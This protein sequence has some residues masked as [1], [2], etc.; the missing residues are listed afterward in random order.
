MSAEN[1]RHVQ[2]LSWKEFDLYQ[3]AAL[4]W[5]L[6]L[7]SPVWTRLTVFHIHIFDAINS[8]QPAAPP[9]TK[10]VQAKAFPTSLQHSWRAVEVTGLPT[11]SSDFPILSSIP[12]V[13]GQ[14]CCGQSVTACVSV[15]VVHY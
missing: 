14:V 8:L 9:S 7:H 15:C 11:E 6:I 5:R 3:K 12:V 13:N 4:A 2:M 1:C 10:G